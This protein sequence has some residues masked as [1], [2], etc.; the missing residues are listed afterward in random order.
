MFVVNCDDLRRV[1][2]PAA[3]DPGARPATPVAVYF[4][5]DQS[6]SM[7]GERYAR[8]L[9]ALGEAIR[10]IRNKAE[11]LNIDATLYVAAHTH[12]PVVQ[13]SGEV[14]VLVADSELLARPVDDTVADIQRRL[15]FRGGGTA[16]KATHELVQKHARALPGATMIV[17]ITDARVHWERD[18]RSNFTKTINESHMFFIFVEQIAQ[19]EALFM[20]A[21]ALR[22]KHI[23]CQTYQTNHAMDTRVIGEVMGAFMQDV[24]DTYHA[25]AMPGLAVHR[26]V[27]VVSTRGATLGPTNTWELRGRLCVSVV[28]GMEPVVHSTDR[29]PRLEAVPCARDANAD[30]DVDGDATGGDGDATKGDGSCES[31]ACESNEACDPA[32]A[33]GSATEVVDIPCTH[34]LSLD[35]TTR[36]LA[37]PEVHPDDR[38]FGGAEPVPT[39]A[40]NGTLVYTNQDGDQQTLAPSDVAVVAKTLATGATS[41]TYTMRWDP[42]FFEGRSTMQI[43]KPRGASAPVLVS[44]ITVRG[45]NVDA[46][47]YVGRVA[48]DKTR[49]DQ[50]AG[51][52]SAA[53]TEMRDQVIESNVGPLSASTASAL[54]EDGCVTVVFTTCVPSPLVP[55]QILIGCHDTPVRIEYRDGLLPAAV[56]SDPGVGCGATIVQAGHVAARGALCPGSVHLLQIELS[57]AA[58]MSRQT[59]EARVVDVADALQVIQIVTGDEWVPTVDD[60]ALEELLLAAARESKCVVPGRIQI[61]ADQTLPTDPDAKPGAFPTVPPRGAAFPPPPTIPTITVDAAG[62]SAVRVPVTGLT[63]SMGAAMSTDP[64]FAGG[65]LGGGGAS[66]VGGGLGGGGARGGGMSKSLSGGGHRVLCA[67]APPEG[68]G[69]CGGTMPQSLEDWVADAHGWLGDKLTALRRDPASVTDLVAQ[70]V[71]LQVKIANLRGMTAVGNTNDGSD[72]EDESAA[73]GERLVSERDELCAGVARLLENIPLPWLRHLVNTSLEYDVVVA[74][75][76][77]T[78]GGPTGL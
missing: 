13:E 55:S 51:A 62:R 67:P 42:T 46:M 5:V 56:L 38:V 54:N 8:L 40:I 66:H 32:G 69:T 6:G 74:V 9:L 70:V 3:E 58:A 17:P 47:R 19:F 65:G 15:P 16:F 71:H 29:G 14:V 60:G 72:T 30:G 63:R 7:R 31:K 33:V 2:P 59:L 1:P 41:V 39:D 52:A 18:W 10:V 53:L 78:F 48:A 27:E 35:D 77:G 37:Q 28:R 49:R 24:L 23:L 20:S 50:E 11:A 68:T 76:S 21:Q 25:D 43:Q 4:V 22:G 73:Y 34:Y 44:G 57:L 45:A 26:S 64:S 36:L 61:F 12:E 75:R